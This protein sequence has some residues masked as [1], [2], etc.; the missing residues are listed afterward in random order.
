MFELRTIK[1]MNCFDFDVSVYY[2]DGLAGSYLTNICPL[3][4]RQ[5]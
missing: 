5:S 1:V 2:E 4:K 3:T